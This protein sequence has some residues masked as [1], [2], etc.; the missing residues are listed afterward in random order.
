MPL[1]LNDR[2]LGGSKGPLHLW[3]LQMDF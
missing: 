1:V 2:P 3:L